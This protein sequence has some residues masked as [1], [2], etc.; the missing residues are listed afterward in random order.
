MKRT[1]ITGTILLL[2]LIFAGGCQ[3]KYNTNVTVSPDG[4]NAEINPITGEPYQDIA[5]KRGVKT[6]ITEFDELL[7]RASK[8]ESYKYILTDTGLTDEQYQF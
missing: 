1:I 3:L 4:E 8:I 7:R 6:N 2:L 5:E